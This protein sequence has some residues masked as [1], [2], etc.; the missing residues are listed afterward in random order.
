MKYGYF[1]P[2]LTCFRSFYDNGNMEK[3]KRKLLNIWHYYKVPFV[4]ITISI[5]LIVFTIINKKNEPKYDYSIAIISKY[6]YPSEENVKKL[7]EIFENKYNGSFN[8][9]IYNVSLGETG[10]DEVILSKLSLDIANKI[11]EYYFI[12]DLDAFKKTT[13]DVQ[14]SSVVLVRDV[15]WLNDLGLDNFHYC[16]R[17]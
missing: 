7:R 3:A 10:E 6:N 5:L 17:K 13:A 9:N 4:I 15:D 8:I 16:I 14:F 11:S 2:Y 12:E 1:K